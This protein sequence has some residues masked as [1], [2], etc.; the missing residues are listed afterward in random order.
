ML[1]VKV[2]DAN[3]VPVGALDD[4]TSLRCTRRWL[5]VGGW[6]L[7]VPATSQALAP[8]LTP[9]AG[10][11]VVEDGATIFSGPVDSGAGGAAVARREL[12]DDNGAVSDQVTVTGSDDMVWLADRVA[13]PSPASGDVSVQ[14]YDA[15]AGVAST[16]IAQYINA[17]CGAG[18]LPARRVTGLVLDTDQVAGAFVTGQGRW[19]NLG[20]LV[21]EL[22]KQGDVNVTVLQDARR[23]LV[24]VV[25]PVDRSQ[26]VVFSPALGNVVKVVVETTRSA[27]SAVYVA[28]RGEGVARAVVEAAGP[29][30]RIEQFVDRRDVDNAPELAV[31]AGTEIVDRVGVTSVSVVPVESG[32]FRFGVDYQ[33]GDMVGV[34]VDEGRTSQRIVAVDIT[35]DQSGFTRSLS[36]GQ[37]A[38][39]GTVAIMSRLNR[40]TRRLNQLERT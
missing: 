7:T 20:Q 12:V 14:A 23:L 35:L 5:G 10:I 11:V 8:L 6:Q 25:A 22:G 15:R 37:V 26:S 36:L 16:V 13:H 19:Q 3:L 33:L 32:S 34:K 21:T 40:H 38:D 9:G 39:S 18:A 17:N 2:R 1:S 30:R 31:I 24:T 28:G 27:A 29:G 4:F